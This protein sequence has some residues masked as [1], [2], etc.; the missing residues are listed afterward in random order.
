MVARRDRTAVEPRGEHAAR[1]GDD[2]RREGDGAHP[3][4]RE[5]GLQQQEDAE[6]GR[7]GEA[8]HAPLRALLVGVVG[9]QLGV[10]LDAGRR[11][12]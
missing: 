2:Q 10:V 3:P 8:E 11:R 1:E 6:R 7:E 4:A 12:P 5:R 9:Q